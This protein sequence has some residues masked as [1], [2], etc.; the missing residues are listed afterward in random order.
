MLTNIFFPKKGDS[1]L[2]FIEGNKI[3]QCGTIISYDWFP[4]I[5]GIGTLPIL[6]IVFYYEQAVSVIIFVDSF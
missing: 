6:A 1:N 4:L 5:F 2:E 3:A